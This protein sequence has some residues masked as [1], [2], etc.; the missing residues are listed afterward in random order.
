MQLIVLRDMSTQAQEDQLP[1]QAR[2]RGFELQFQ[3]KLNQQL[4]PLGL[5]CLEAQCKLKDSRTITDAWSMRAGT[6]G[7]CFLFAGVHLCLS[8][9]ATWPHVFL[10][11]SQIL[12]KS[13]LNSCS[14]ISSIWN[15]RSSLRDF[16]LKNALRHT[17]SQHHPLKGRLYV[18]G[19]RWLSHQFRT[20]RSARLAQRR[21][22]SCTKQGFFSGRNWAATHL[23]M[24]HNRVHICFFLKYWCYQ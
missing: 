19:S 17:A 24:A 21:V 15:T 23:D 16:H 6:A 20:V 10:P 18:I 13:L 2:L 9:L 4:K 1:P 22:G 12:L 14:Y 3:V 7:E 11:T 5:T 8:H